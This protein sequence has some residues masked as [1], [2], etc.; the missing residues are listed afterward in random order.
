[1]A[2]LNEAGWTADGAFRVDVLLAFGGFLVAL[3]FVG[4][5]RRSEDSGGGG[6]D[7]GA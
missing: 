1:M 5:R 6:P 2:L 4:E 7:A 3:L